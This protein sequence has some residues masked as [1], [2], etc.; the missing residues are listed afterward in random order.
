MSRQVKCGI[1]TDCQ[2]VNCERH[3]LGLLLSRAHDIEC[4]F[5]EVT[6]ESPTI[7]LCKIGE[8]VL[9]GGDNAAAVRILET[10]VSEMESLQ[11]SLEECE[12]DILEEAGCIYEWREVG[13]LAKEVRTVVRG[14]EEI[15]CDIL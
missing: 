7:Y 11:Q 2:Y 9:Q 3:T 15:L 5:D 1:S 14:L 13:R 6:E 4:R 10:K 8:D 12:A